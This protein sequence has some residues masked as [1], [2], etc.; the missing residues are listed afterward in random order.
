MNKVSYGIMNF[1]ALFKVVSVH[2]PYKVHVSDTFKKKINY[3]L[4]A[5]IYTHAKFVYF[6]YYLYVR[7]AFSLGF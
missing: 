2:V 6:T 4:E 1:I 7:P 3:A 5:C